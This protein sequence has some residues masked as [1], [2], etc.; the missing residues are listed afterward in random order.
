M[1]LNVIKNEIESMLEGGD[2]HIRVYE[3][4]EGHSCISI[5]D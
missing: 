3:K 2:I 5:E 4:T 1:L